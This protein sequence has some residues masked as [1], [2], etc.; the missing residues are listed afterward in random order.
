[1]SRIDR[2]F[3]TS[4]SVRVYADSQTGQRAADMKYRQQWNAPIK[5]S[6]HNPDVVYTTSQYVHRTTNARTRLGSRSAP[7]SRATTRRKQDYSGGEGITRDNTGVE[8]YSTIFVLEESTIAPG[9]LWA[10]SDDGLVH[11][12]RD[13]GK[14]WTNVTPKDWPEGC[15]NSIDPSV[16]RS[17]RARRSRCTG[18]VRATSRRTSTRPTTTAR[19]G[20]GSRT[21]RTAFRTGTSRASSA[22][23]RRARDCSTPARSSVST[24]SFDDGAHWQSLQLNLPITP[25]TDI[26]I[27]RDDLIVDDA[28]SRRS[29]FSTTCR[30][31]AGRRRGCRQPLDAMLFKP[32]DG[33]RVGTAGPVPTFY[34]WFR[35]AP[36]APVTV[37]DSIAKRRNGRCLHRR[38][39]PMAAGG[40][41]QPPVRRRGQVRRCRRRRWRPAVLVAA[42]GGGGA[43]AVAG[44][45]AAAGGRGVRRGGACEGTA[46][47]P[48][49]RQRHPA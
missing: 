2:K 39:R 38:R 26:M 8:V 28:G 34:Y 31:C 35:E 12:S 47:G 29:G 27:Y 45:G 21:A 44:E 22:K 42:G 23:I 16:A 18:T 1:M 30:C 13:N 4:E 11:V 36:T 46:T 37:D 7:I 5:I 25:V 17:R 24:S 9:L 19:P 40:T 14:T 15:I 6:P 3:N 43:A 20:G 41:R 48:A 33:Y 10:G 49:G 32:E